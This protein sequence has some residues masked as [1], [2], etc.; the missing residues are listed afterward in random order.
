MGLINYPNE[1]DDFAD[2]TDD[3]DDIM[4]IHLNKA[5]AAVVALETKM[6]AGAYVDDL[7]TLVLNFI[8]SGRRIYCYRSATPTGW[9]IVSAADYI[10]AVSGGSGAYSGAGG[11]MGGTTWASLKAHTHNHNSHLHTLATHLHQWYNNNGAST[12]HQVVN[13]GGSWVTPASKAGSSTHFSLYYGAYAKTATPPDAYTD[14]QAEVIV[15]ST[16]ATGG[17]SYSDVRPTAAVGQVI[18]KDAP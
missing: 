4:S 18:Q 12:N 3:V 10:L 5:Q 6:G 15:A 9:S 17:G 2:K 1:L 7:K 8:V 14:K 13:S 11:T 16:A